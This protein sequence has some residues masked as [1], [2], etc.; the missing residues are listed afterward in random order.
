VATLYGDLP[1]VGDITN[2]NIR[3][4]LDVRRVERDAHRGMEKLTRR[5]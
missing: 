1:N 3:P 4:V 5:R 2:K